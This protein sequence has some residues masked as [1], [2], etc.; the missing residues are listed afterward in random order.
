MLIECIGGSWFPHSKIHFQTYLYTLYLFQKVLWAIIRNFCKSRSLLKMIPPPPRHKNDGISY[1]GKTTSC[2]CIGPLV[3]ISHVPRQRVFVMRW[4]VSL[5][6]WTRRLK[7][8]NYEPITGLWN[9]FLGYEYNL[10]HP[11]YDKLTPIIH[12]TSCHW[13]IM[14]LQWHT[15]AW[16]TRAGINDR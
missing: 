9:G 14:D 11:L 10:N 15:F 3:T 12:A 13:H 16:D 8:F 7:N 5:E 1:S 4:F 2:Y 6:R